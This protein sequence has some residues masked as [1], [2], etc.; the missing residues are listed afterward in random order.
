MT[1]PLR[2]VPYRVVDA[3]TDRPFGGNPAGVVLPGGE[4]ASPSE[5]PDPLLQAVARE[6]N[7]SET[8][9]PHPEEE[10]GMRRLRWF[11]PTTEVTLC[12]HA[13]LAAAHALLEAGAEAP[14]HFSSLSG[15][16]SVYREPSGELRLDF[17]AD[18]P[19][20]VEPPPGLLSALGIA[21]DAGA[22]FATGARCALVELPGGDR[23]ALDLLD[24]EMRALGEVT[25]PPGV[26][27]VSVTVGLSLPAHAEGDAAAAGDATGRG[28]GGA[29]EGGETLPTFA[30]RFFG[31]WVGVD[32]D[33]VTGMAHCLLGPWW[34]DRTGAHTFRAL[35][36]RNRKGELEVRVRGERVHLVGRA[37]TVAEGHLLLPG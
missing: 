2:R 18:P 30:S 25:L 17:P 24:P 13:T 12:G 22:R 36:G 10:G 21:P 3:F 37:F 26:M 35:Q 34:A 23:K 1:G 20:E 4:F 16:L 33:P 27:G 7:L 29:G 28:R 32:E 6:L 31:P 9:F 8:A 11:T 14:L 19:R 5:L 15:P